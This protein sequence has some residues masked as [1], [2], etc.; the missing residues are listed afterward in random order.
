MARR[1]RRDRFRRGHAAALTWIG[2]GLTASVALGAILFGA[3]SGVR[4]IAEALILIGVPG[5]AAGAVAVAVVLTTGFLVALAVGTPFIVAGE[6][7]LVALAQRRVASRQART[8]RTI[9]RELGGRARPRPVLDPEPA[10][11]VNRLAPR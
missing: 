4:S 10:R 9:R 5:A 8:L 6:L 7:I 2:W 3:L 11:L 1:P